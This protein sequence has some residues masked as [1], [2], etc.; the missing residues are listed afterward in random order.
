MRP[1]AA[2]GTKGTGLGWW[3]RARPSDGRLRLPGGPHI[4]PPIYTH[5]QPDGC[6]D[7][8]SPHGCVAVD[9]WPPLTEPREQQ[10]L[11]LFPRP[12]VWGREPNVS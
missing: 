12:D 10:R 7:T 5:S 1:R 11:L 8:L 9:K 3:Q 6:Q 2:L 4:L